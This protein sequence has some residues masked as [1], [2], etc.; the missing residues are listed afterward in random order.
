MPP[1]HAHRGLYTFPVHHPYDRYAMPDL[2]TPDLAA[3][4]KLGDVRGRSILLQPGDLLF[5]PAHW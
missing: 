1:G 3:W 4:P 2:D 5:V